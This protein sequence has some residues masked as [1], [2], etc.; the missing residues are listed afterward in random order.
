[1]ADTRTMAQYDAK[2][3][4]RGYEDA[5][6][7]ILK[8]L[9]TNSSKSKVN[10]SSPYKQFLILRHVYQRNPTKLK[11]LYFPTRSLHKERSQCSN[12]YDEAMHL[13]FIYRGSSPTMA[14]KRTTTIYS[15]YGTDDLV[16][17]FINQFFLLLRTNDDIRTEFTRFTKDSQNCINLIHFY[18]AMNITDQDSLNSAA[19]GNFL[20]KMPRECLKIIESKSKVRQTRAKAVIAKVSTNSSTQTVSPDVAELKDIVRALLLDKKE[21]Q[22]SAEP[23]PASCTCQAFD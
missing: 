19:G 6:P 22:A 9:Q 5:I 10:Q 15:N 11:N 8:L 18:K 17:K 4:P 2:H 21:P 20:D 14:R 16:S 12:C 13:P 1:M 23:I 7:Y 3:P